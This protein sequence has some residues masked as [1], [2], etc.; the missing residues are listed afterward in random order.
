MPERFDEPL[1]A[2]AL[3]SRSGAGRLVC[4]API[5]NAPFCYPERGSSGLID[6]L[7]PTRERHPMAEMIAALFAFPI[8]IMSVLLLVVLAY[9]SLVIIGGLDI[10]FLDADIDTG[11]GEGDIETGDGGGILGALGLGGV[12]LTVV[13]SFQVLFS[14]M[15]TAISGRLWDGVAGLV[16]GSAT[17]LASFAVA[18][19]VTIFAIKPLRPFFNTP[20]APTRALL[21]G[22][23]CT[24]TTLRVDEEFGQARYEEG[25]DDM[26][27]QVRGSAA[28]ALSKGSKVL[29]ISEEKAGNHFN[30][31]PYDDS[32]EAQ[33]LEP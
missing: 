10:D 12:P 33:L 8:G 3:P 30:V 4:F 25:S 21:I 26:V 2:F 13:V 7:K 9:W 27:I 15:L 29:V 24:V 14:W 5:C 23:V 32:A 22:K 17:L 28:D 6:G 19:G 18:L 20:N 16:I 31:I 1:E 11:G